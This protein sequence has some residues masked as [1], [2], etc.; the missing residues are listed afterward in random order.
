MTLHLEGDPLLPLHLFVLPSA[1]AGQSHQGAGLTDC[2]LPMCII[3]LGINGD[4]LR[5]NIKFKVHLKT[6]ADFSIMPA[7]V[8]IYAELLKA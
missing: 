7:E 1:V 6:P 4:S 8:L 3:S 2:S 5:F